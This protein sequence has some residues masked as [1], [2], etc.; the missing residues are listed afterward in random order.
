[1]QILKD[2]YVITLNPMNEYGKYSIVIDEGKIIDILKENEKGA[3]E[4]QK[5]LPD[6]YKN[7][8]IIDCSNKIIMPPFINSCVKSEGTLIKYLLKNRHYEN[9]TEDLCTDFIFNYIYQEM[10]SNEITDD[11][12][13]LYRYSLSKNLKSGTVYINEFTPRKDVNHIEPILNT[14]KIT[15]QNVTICYPIKQDNKTLEKYKKLNVSYYLTDENQITIYEL[16]ALSELKKYNIKNLFLEVS[17]NKHVCEEFKKIY[18][19]PI[20]SVLDEYSL[21]DDKTSIINPIY[22]SY[23]ELKIIKDTGASIIICP[24]DLSYFT[25]RY[26]PIDDFLTHKIKYSIGSGWLGEDIF[27]EIR[28]FRNKYKELN[29]SSIDLLDS[30]TKTPKS[31]YFDEGEFPEGLYYIDTNKEANLIFIDTS[32]LRFQFYPEDLSFEKL[33]D[34]LVDNLNT[35]IISDVMIKGKKVVQDNNLTV[36]EEELIIKEASETRKR[37]YKVGKYNE[38]QERKNEKKFINEIDLRGRDDDEIKLFSNTDKMSEDNK[39]EK[40]E[41][42]IKGKLAVFKHKKSSVQKSLFD[43]E[44][45]IVSLS[46]EEQKSPS[47]NLLISEIIEIKGTDEEIERLKETEKKLFNKQSEKKAHQVKQ[48]TDEGKIELPKDVKLKFGDD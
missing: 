39:D 9:K 45:Q 18:N 17:T 21:I 2:G 44:P 43:D 31:L 28:L 47:L 22:L 24:R 19:K 20:I 7:A 46:E 12:N 10:P 8:E 1:M 3:K 14:T 35:F 38:L 41:F 40:E 26:F 11:L 32:D 23:D 4:K 27:K 13:I 36:F 34:F 29:L 16:S 30:I 42:R 33:C 6:K 37:L 25:N 15:G 5:P 48:T